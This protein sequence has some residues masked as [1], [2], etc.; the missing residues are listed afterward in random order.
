MVQARMDGPRACRIDT[1]AGERI[2]C[3][4]RAGRAEAAAYPGL[5]WLGGFNSTMEGTKAGALDRFAG[6]RGLACV[7]F[8]YSGHGA[9]SGAFEDGTVGTW[10]GEAEAV[11]EQVATGPQL[12]VGSSMGGWLA[13]LLARRHLARTTRSR[14]AGL[15]LIAPAVDMTEELMWALF[16]EDARREIETTGVYLRPS[17]Y[18][19]GPYPITRALIEEG[20]GHLML[21]RPFDPGCPVRI[22]HGA[23]DADVPWPLSLRLLDCLT[24]AD[25][26]LT[27]IPDGD[28]RLSRPEDI[29]RLLRT[30]E[31]LVFGNEAQE[32]SG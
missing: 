14:I 24:G 23:R 10:L 5:M 22:L 8:D 2:A 13:L 16:S 28:H 20:R 27:L 9:S 18:G 25:A 1:P 17:A 30:V 7:R 12:L 31:G 11:F 15:V 29:E 32:P 3:L 26:D 19:D 4:V 6:E 21:G